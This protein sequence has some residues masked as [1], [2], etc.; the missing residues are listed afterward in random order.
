M[1]VVQTSPLRWSLVV[2]RLDEADI[3]ATT[4]ETQEEGGKETQPNTDSH[5]FRCR[6]RVV[7]PKMFRKLQR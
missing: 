7:T 6:A 5:L 3:P 1:V 2:Y 4:C